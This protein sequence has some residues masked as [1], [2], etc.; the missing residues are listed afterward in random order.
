MGVSGRELNFHQ[1]SN[2]RNQINAL[3]KIIC[4]TPLFPVFFL[5]CIHPER[6]R[7]RTNKMHFWESLA[8]TF[9]LC[10]YL[11]NLR[12]NF[13]SVKKYPRN[14]HQG[15]KIQIQMRAEACLQDL[16]IKIKKI[17]PKSP[18][19]HC[20]FPIKVLKQ[21]L[22]QKL[23][24]SLLFVIGKGSTHILMSLWWKVISQIFTGI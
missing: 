8:F 14:F 17:F 19:W 24:I 6:Q 15:S 13:P 20:I 2:S 11:N 4:S 1:S 23:M 21:E 5:L 10:S 22:S 9:A 3:G 7:G 16:Q 18:V 12:G